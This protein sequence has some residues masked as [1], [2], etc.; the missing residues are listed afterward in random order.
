MI[1]GCYKYNIRRTNK[2]KEI[3]KALN[4]SKYIDQF[5]AIFY[6]KVNYFQVYFFVQRDERPFMEQTILLRVRNKQNFMVD[7]F[8]AEIS[9]FLE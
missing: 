8:N 9:F 5:P 6:V 2:F 4:D 1:W 7:C 3:E